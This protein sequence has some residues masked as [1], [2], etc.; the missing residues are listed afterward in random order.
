MSLELTH[1]AL[2]TAAM[3]ELQRQHAPNVQR[4][5][6]PLYRGLH[7]LRHLSCLSALLLWE[8]VKCTSG[9]VAKL[10]SGGTPH[11]VQGSATLHARN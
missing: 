11:P 10:K 5:G 3:R 2:K 6:A 7:V 8:R 1:P 4:H 9:H